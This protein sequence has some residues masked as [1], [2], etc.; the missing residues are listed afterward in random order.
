VRNFDQL[1]AANLQINL[2]VGSLAS[3]KL[4]KLIVNS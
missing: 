2:V 3:F 1:S 4:M